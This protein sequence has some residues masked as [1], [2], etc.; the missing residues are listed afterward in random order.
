MVG[1][2]LI[3][4]IQREQEISLNNLNGEAVGN[5]EAI[6]LLMAIIYMFVL[7]NHLRMPGWSWR[8]L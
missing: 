2:I 4:Y 7:I 1:I 3:G 6:V 8:N 5:I